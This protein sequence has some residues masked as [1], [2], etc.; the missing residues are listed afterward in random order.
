VVLQSY[1]VGN[2]HRCRVFAGPA[3]IVV[4]NSIVSPPTNA[5]TTV[6]IVNPAATPQPV[7]LT[8]ELDYLRAFAP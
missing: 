1:V 5:W 2:T 3:A 7:P 6:A 8:A 4:D